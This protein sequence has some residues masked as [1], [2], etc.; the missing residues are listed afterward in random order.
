[1]FDNVCIL[2]SMTII[3]ILRVTRT[4]YL[5]IIFSIPIMS[6]PSF[7]CHHVCKLTGKKHTIMNH[8]LHSKRNKLES[9]EGATTQ[10]QSNKEIY[11]I[12]SCDNHI[13]ISSFTYIFF[14]VG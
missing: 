11:Y 8:F 2:I 14:M 13:N 10:C 7:K 1:M 12:F 4:I 3:I 6:S 5:K 9:G